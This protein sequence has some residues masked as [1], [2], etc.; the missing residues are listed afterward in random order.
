M[1]DGQ[2]QFPTHSEATCPEVLCN[3]ISLLL[4]DEMLQQGAL[5]VEDLT[6][7]VKGRGKSLNRVVLGAFIRGKH[8]KPLVSEY[9]SY[10]RAIN[11]VQSEDGLH[12][13]MK[14]LPYG[15]SLQSRLLTTGGEVRDAIAKQGKKRMIEKN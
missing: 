12:S 15:A 3:R 2:V 14:A 1:I 5:D 6:K 7:Q 11:S 10:V 8:V 13:F 4:K 9:G